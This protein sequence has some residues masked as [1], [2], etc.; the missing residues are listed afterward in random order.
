[1]WALSL[2]RGRVCHLQLL[3]ALASTVILGSESLGARDHI[4]LSQIRD[5]TFRRL[6]LLAGP[7]WRYSSPPPHGIDWR[8]LNWPP[9]IQSKSH[10]AI[11]GQSIGKSWCRDPSWGSWPDIYYSLTVMVL[12][13][14]G[15]LSDGRTGLS[16][17]Y[18]ASLLQHSR[19]RVRDF[20]FRRLIQLAGLRCMYSTPPPQRCWSGLVW[21]GLVWSG[22]PVIYRRAGQPEETSFNIVGKETSVY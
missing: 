5:F 21:S 14:W 6:L 15:A 19:S 13:L 17:V 9:F 4:L 10:I 16:F 1:M 20:P 2:T 11:D 3:L 8:L 22:F 18:A 7:R 12:F